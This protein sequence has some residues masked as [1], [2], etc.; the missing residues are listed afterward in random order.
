MIDW[1]LVGYPGKEIYGVCMTCN[2]EVVSKKWDGYI[3]YKYWRDK[4]KKEYEVCPYCAGK[5]VKASLTPPKFEKQTNGD[6]LAKARNGDFLIWKYGR[7]FKWRYREY[8]RES[9]NCVGFASK[10]SIA[11][12]MCAKHEGWQGV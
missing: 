9:A 11:K 5:H 7:A 8:G 6:W 10:L 12:K 3:D 4:L 1:R 2:K